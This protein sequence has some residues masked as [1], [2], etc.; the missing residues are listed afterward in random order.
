MTVEG[1]R[2]AGGPVRVL[3][4]SA[5]FGEGGAQRVTSV[6][7]RSLDRSRFAPAVCGFR[8]SRAFDFGGDVPLFRVL[9][10]AELRGRSVGRAIVGD[11][12]LAATL[13]RR[14]R[15]AIV[16]FGPEVVVSNIASVAAVMPLVLGGFCSG[17]RPRWVARLGGNPWRN[18]AA[19]R[20][21]LRRAL[22]SADVVVANSSRL[23]ETVTRRWGLPAETARNPVPPGEP[24]VRPE[25]R[26]GDP[27]RA[28]AIGRAERVKRYDVML[29]AV[30]RVRA[31]GVPLELTICGDGSGLGA[32][33]RGIE[34]RG[35]SGAVRA[36]GHVEGPSRLL[37]EADLFLITSDH[38]GSPNALLEAQLAGVPAVA[39][40]CDFGPDEIIDDGVTGRLVPVGD[41]AALAAAITDTFAVPAAEWAGRFA[42]SGKLADFDFDR[43]V[44]AW[45]DLLERA[46]GRGLDGD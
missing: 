9:T 28:L 36:L 17:D 8:E 1:G 19:G 33:R 31:G 4:V 6:L 15:D 42:R 43:C 23:A 7:T 38:E 11:P 22:R 41:A 24:I 21:V 10:E 16:E 45:S 30:A 46:A 25:R 27:P 12:R 13:V 44:A 3:F 35:L 32:L 39:T 40:A 5:S 14:V 2:A 34:D 18:G 26:P 37:A 29:D 20:F